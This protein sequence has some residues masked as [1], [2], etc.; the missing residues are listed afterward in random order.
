MPDR[1]LANT[2]EK[3]LAK[4]RGRNVVRMQLIRVPAIN[5]AVAVTLFAGLVQGLADWAVMIPVFVPYWAVSLVLLFVAWRAP[6]Y[7][8][9]I[10]WVGALIDFPVVFY[11]Q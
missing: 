2:I 5:L 6:K 9:T 10:G 4:E 3:E 1:T 7:A 8:R 11:L